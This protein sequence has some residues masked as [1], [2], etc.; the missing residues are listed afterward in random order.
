MSANGRNGH[1]AEDLV[2]FEAN[3]DAG[4]RSAHRR[5]LEAVD[6]AAPMPFDAMLRA[7]EDGIEGGEAGVGD[8][9]M[10]Q[11]V[12]GVRAFL[13][14]VKGRGVTL[15]RIMKQL[16]AAGRAM[17]DPF[18]A[19]LTMTESG[20]IFSETKAGHSF[21]CK[22]LSG[23][24]ELAGMKGIKL[25]GQKSPES[26][27]VYAAVQKGNSNR[28]KKTGTIRQ[29]SFLKQLHTKREIRRQKGSGG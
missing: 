13:R 21:R 4:L 3:M 22:L 27:A 19:R 9:E 2:V 8:Y 28:A 16:F 11:R 18:F 7:E 24:I 14:F 12:V 29:G 26:S 23:E 15:P 25:P 17:G 1:S 10:R 20:L 6:D 5:G